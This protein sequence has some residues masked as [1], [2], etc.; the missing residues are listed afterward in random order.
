MIRSL[1]FATS[2]GIIRFEDTFSTLSYYAA[3]RPRGDILSSGADPSKLAQ[4]T[5]STSL[6]LGLVWYGCSQQWLA[7]RIA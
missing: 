4:F 3:H 1:I 7:S 5:L 2:D 6:S